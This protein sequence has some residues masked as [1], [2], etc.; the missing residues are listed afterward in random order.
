METDVRGGKDI[1]QELL[2]V[3]AAVG[4]NN[5]WRP[6]YDAE[7]NLVAPGAGYVTD[8]I[9][10]DFPKDRFRGKSVVDMGCNFG[11]YSFLAKSLGATKVVGIDIDDQLI[12][13][14]NLQKA[15]HSILDVYFC[16][17]DLLKYNPPEKFDMAM[18][19]DTIGKNFVQTGVLKD[20]LDAVERCARDEMVISVRTFYRIP[21]HFNVDPNKLAAIYSDEFIR[22]NRFYSL[23]Y[24]QWYFKENWETAYLS[25][26]PRPDERNKRTVLFV[27]K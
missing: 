10:D 16:S 17:E 15:M 5:I 25:S 19:L 7:G 26:E 4:L 18:L 20:F 9:P 14:C 3:V 23:E 2:N 12:R 27:R 6:V 1:K 13:G 21:K 22:G 8:G 11:Y 24:V